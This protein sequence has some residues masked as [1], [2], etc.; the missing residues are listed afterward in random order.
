MMSSTTPS[1]KY[2]F[3]GSPPRFENGSTAIEG[4]VVSSAATGTA[5][6]G[7]GGSSA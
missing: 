3:F 5:R 7:L 4:S 2:S 6:A 1:A